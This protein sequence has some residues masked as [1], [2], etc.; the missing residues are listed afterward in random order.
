MWSE[1]VRTTSH[2]FVLLTNEANSLFLSPLD[3]DLQTRN[4]KVIPR[5]KVSLV[6]F[7]LS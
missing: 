5:F 4:G 1:Q 3:E 2:Q 6:D 7:L